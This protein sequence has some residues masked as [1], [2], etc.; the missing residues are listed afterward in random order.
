MDLRDSPHL[1][2]ATSADT[3][4]SP[5]RPL[6]I[7]ALSVLVIGALGWFAFGRT[8]GPAP[9]SAPPVQTQAAKPSAAEP[10]AREAAGPISGESKPETAAAAA[11][12]STSAPGTVA[13]AAPNPA[14]PAPAASAATDA[15]VPAPAAAVTNPSTAPELKMDIEFASAKRIVPFAFNK[16]G[17]G[18]RGLL[19]VKELAPLAKQAE[20]VYVRGRTDGLGGTDANRKVA[21]DRAYTVFYAFL[22]EGVQK[23]KLRL[24]YCSTCFAASNDTEEGRRLNRRVEVELLMPPEAITRLPKPVH[25][26]EAPPPLIAPLASSEILQSIPR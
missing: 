19:A 2:N 5:V 4:A 8:T 10:P 21:L 16:V 11:P 3:I 1:R 13:S 6:L 9:V 22:R 17:V 20:K 14:I 12:A 24:T 18:P 15:A 25:A 26:P 23:N 7:A